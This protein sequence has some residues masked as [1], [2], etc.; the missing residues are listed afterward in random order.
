LSALGGVGACGS[1]D[2]AETRTTPGHLESRLAADTGARWLVERDE[3]GAA[4][5]L[6]ALSAPHA[7]APGM[8]LDQAALE[9]L[10][11]YADDFGAGKLADELV[12]RSDDADVGAPGVHRLRFAQR[13]PRSDV[14]VFG[15]DTFVHFDEAGVIRFAAVGLVGQIARIPKSPTTTADQARTIAEGTI[16][17]M[18][19]QAQVTM[20]RAPELVVHRV[21][22]GKGALAWRVLLVGTVAG[23]FSAPEVCVDALTSTVR[24]TNDAAAHASRTGLLPNVFTYNDCDLPDP[25]A[26]GG[27]SKVV[28]VGPVASGRAGACSPAAA[29]VAG[30]ESSGSRARSPASPC[31][32]PS[33]RRRSSWGRAG[34]SSASRRPWAPRRSTSRPPRRTPPRSACSRGRTEH[35]RRART[36][37]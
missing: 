24:E 5:F 31:W 8:P 1:A 17:Q 3:A 15:A 9:F 23:A 34:S 22:G 13:I 28:Q 12:L 20:P 14:H 25:A 37:R 36:A 30:T 32:C 4:L 7:K 27:R 11:R 21:A 35:R 33:S 10:Q 29:S 19:P 18:A 2:D 26:P 16:L 6:S